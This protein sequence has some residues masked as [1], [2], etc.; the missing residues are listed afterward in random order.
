MGA[1]DMALAQYKLSKLVPKR[2]DA[3]RFLGLVIELDLVY[4]GDDSAV[5][6]EDRRLCLGFK[7]GYV[8]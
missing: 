4:C 6:E 5:T 7:D 3:I 2:A 8:P 1:F